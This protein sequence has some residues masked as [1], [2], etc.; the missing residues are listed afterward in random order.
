MGV[1]AMLMMTAVQHDWMKQQMQMH[2]FQTQLE[3][4]DDHQHDD[5][6]LPLSA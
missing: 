3:A 2:R 1:I 6:H 5:G 4:P